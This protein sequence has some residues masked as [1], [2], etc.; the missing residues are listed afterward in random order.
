MIRIIDDLLTQCPEIGMV[1]IFAA[2]LVILGVIVI[3]LE[4]FLLE[5]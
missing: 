5:S 3:M 2:S 1:L 4:T